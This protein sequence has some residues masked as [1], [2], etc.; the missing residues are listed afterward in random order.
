MEPHSYFPRANDKSRGLAEGIVGTVEKKDYDR[1]K[2][3]GW[4]GRPPVED[5]VIQE[6]QGAIPPREE[7]NL[8][9]SDVGVALLRR[10][11]RKSMDDV[12]NGR[13]AKPVM[14]D[15][16]GI[17]EVD[18]FK[19]L[20]NRSDIVLGPENMPSSKNGQGLIRDETGR[21]AFA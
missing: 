1:R 14:S 2:Y 7:E 19:G 3:A 21:L 4:E 18:T 5:L 17:V 10:I 8:V 11:W 6:S 12:A 15:N 13:P 20:A 9:S 16:Q